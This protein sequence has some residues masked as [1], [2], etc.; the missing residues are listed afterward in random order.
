[1]DRRARCGGL[2][3]VDEHELTSKRDVAKILTFA[4]HGDLIVKAHLFLL[5]KSI[6]KV[7]LCERVLRRISHA[8]RLRPRFHR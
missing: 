8:V 4:R 6:A 5:Q 1:M 2:W 7:L 3:G